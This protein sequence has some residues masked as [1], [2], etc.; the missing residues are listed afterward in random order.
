MESQLEM[1]EVTKRI[2]G[3]EFLKAPPRT[4]RLRYRLSEMSGVNIV[5]KKTPWP[6]S[7]SE[8]YRATAACR[9]S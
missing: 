3:A 9:R 7:V 8:L 1:K 4:V 2:T 6:E 5:E